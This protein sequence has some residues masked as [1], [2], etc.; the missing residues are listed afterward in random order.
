MITPHSFTATATDPA[1]QTDYSAFTPKVVRVF[2]AITI[3]ITV[4][5]LFLFGI[6]W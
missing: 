4:A 2:L 5:I 1:T 6:A 3:P